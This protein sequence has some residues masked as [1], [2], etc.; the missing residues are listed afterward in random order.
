[1][2]KKVEEKALFK[3]SL[4]DAVETVCV[5]NRSSLMLLVIYKIFWSL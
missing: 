1:M 5:P 3:D 2:D 4:S